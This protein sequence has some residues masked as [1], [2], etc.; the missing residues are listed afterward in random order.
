MKRC[1]PSPSTPRPTVNCL[2]LFT[3]SVIA[4]SAASRVFTLLTHHLRSS[5]HHGVVSTRAKK[6]HA[7]S[8]DV[9][10]CT[11]LEA[12]GPAR[13]T[14]VRRLHHRRHMCPNHTDDDQ[15]QRLPVSSR[16]QRHRL[17]CLPFELSSMRSS[18]PLRPPRRSRGDIPRTSTAGRVRST[19]DSSGRPSVTADTLVTYRER[20]KTVNPLSLT[21][22]LLPPRAS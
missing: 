19:H 3:S 15:M 22:L 5:S 21:R 4:S 1:D 8:S 6:D 7:V 11:G 17:L 12:S 20:P 13:A 10:R 16:H 2:S 18:E 14:L 9:K